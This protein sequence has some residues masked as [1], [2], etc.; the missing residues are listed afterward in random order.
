[1]V[2]KIYVITVLASGEYICVNVTYDKVCRVRTE[3][4]PLLIN[5]SP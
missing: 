2:N 3:T 5:A 1:M 4:I